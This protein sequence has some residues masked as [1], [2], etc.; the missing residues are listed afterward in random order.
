[1]HEI[2]Y[3]YIYILANRKMLAQDIRTYIGKQLLS[4]YYSKLSLT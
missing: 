2:Y 4:M 3:T 1:M